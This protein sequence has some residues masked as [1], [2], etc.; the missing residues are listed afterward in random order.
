MACSSSVS[1]ARDRG[2]GPGAVHRLGDG[3]AARHLADVLAEVADGHAAI[4]R[5][6]ALVGLLLAP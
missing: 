2:D 3:A 1:S 4:D 6:L 5:D